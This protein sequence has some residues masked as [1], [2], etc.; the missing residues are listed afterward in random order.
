MIPKIIHY[1]WFGRGGYP[2]SVI[3]CIESWKKYCPDYEIIE[4]N[5]DNF[6]VNYNDFTK[7]AYE[8]KRYAFVSDVARLY[9]LTQYGGVYV[10]TDVEIIRPLDDNILCYK[11]VTCFQSEANVVATAFMT[12]EKGLPIY[13]EFL[14]QYDGLH[15]L[16]S[17]G[18]CNWVTNNNLMTAKC[19]EYGLI[20]NN[21]R[22]EIK[23]LVIFPR[24]YFSPKNPI[25]KDLNIT[26][27]TYVIH[28]FDGSWYSDIRDY[29]DKLRKKYKFLPQK[30]INFIAYT[31]LRGLRASVRAA[32]RWVKEKIK[33][34]AS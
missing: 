8:A 18:S 7:E 14:S 25:T 17:D 11:G 4:W 19:L 31:K 1:C 23:D 9:A 13:L 32:N 5:E 16:N 10:D 21:R 15:F 24:E 26:N 29:K 33:S 20:Q 30:L 2:E 12:A 28:H 6:D 3:K 34:K 22:Q 27:C